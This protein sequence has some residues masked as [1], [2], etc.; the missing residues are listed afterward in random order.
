MAGVAVIGTPLPPSTWNIHSLAVPKVP[1][2]RDTTT[3]F[4]SGDHAGDT[5]M[6][7]LPVVSAVVSEPSAFI[8]QTFSAPDRSD[9]KAI[10]FPSGEKRGCASY[11]MPCVRRVAFPPVIG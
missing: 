6:F 4:P 3:Y 2:D 9:T 7:T 11:A 5:Y 10:F 8:V 1:P